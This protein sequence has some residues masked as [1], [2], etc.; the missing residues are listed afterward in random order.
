VDPRGAKPLLPTEEKDEEEEEP[1]IVRYPNNTISLAGLTLQEASPTLPDKWYNVI[2]VDLTRQGRQTYYLPISNV[3]YI[4]KCYVD[5]WGDEVTVSC[6]LIEHGAVEPKSSYGRWFTKL[7]Q[8]TEKSIE[9]KENGFVFGEPLSIAE[10]LGGADVALLFIRSKATYY[11]PFPD[12]TELTRYWRNTP[13]W[14]EFRTTLQ[15]LV[16]FVEK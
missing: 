7:S 15:E 5:V 13:E 4:G 16:P 8:V 14:K 12:G 3:R 11:L 2:P 9:S 1:E 10:D 6:S